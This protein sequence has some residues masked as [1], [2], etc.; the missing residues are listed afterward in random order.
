MPADAAVVLPFEDGSAG[1]FCPVV[2]DNGFGLSIEADDRVQLSCNAGARKR[3]IGDE[4]DAFTGAI[5]DDAEH[6]E[7]PRIAENIR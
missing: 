6:A 2:A 1:Q 7:P 3:R 5:V 4:A